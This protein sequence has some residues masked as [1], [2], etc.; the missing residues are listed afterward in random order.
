MQALVEIKRVLTRITTH[1]HAC[2]NNRRG[3]STFVMRRHARV[4]LLMVLAKAVSLR[5]TLD[6]FVCYGDADSQTRWRSDE[7]RG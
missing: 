7:A 5:L 2:V 6:R 1:Q 3:P 4:L